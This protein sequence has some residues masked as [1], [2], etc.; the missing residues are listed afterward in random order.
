MSAD[1]GRGHDRRLGPGA[2]PIVL[3]AAMGGSYGLPKY[4]G[5]LALY[6]NK[7]LFDDA[8]VAYPTQAGP[9]D[10]YLDAPCSG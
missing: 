1:V 9:Y 8:G 10:D 6:Y 2:V 3:H 4:H 7:D 5:A